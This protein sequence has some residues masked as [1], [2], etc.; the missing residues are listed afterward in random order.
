MYEDPFLDR[1]DVC[2]DGHTRASDILFVGYIIHD[3]APVLEIGRCLV[4][5]LLAVLRVTLIRVVGD[6]LAFVLADMLLT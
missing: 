2:D 1:R 5:K 4:G 3:G 6:Q